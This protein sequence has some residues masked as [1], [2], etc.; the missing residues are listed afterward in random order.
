MMLNEEH[1]H[2]TGE[3]DRKENFRVEWRGYFGMR[4]APTG[5]RE[6]YQI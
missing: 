4:K 3:R 1:I 5:F 6:K 2:K